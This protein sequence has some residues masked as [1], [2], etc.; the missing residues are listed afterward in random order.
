MKARLNPFASKRLLQIRY[1]FQ[2]ETWERLLQRLAQ[3]NYRAAIVGPEGSGKTTL[4]EDLAIS[5]RNRFVLKWFT[6]S[7]NQE[8]EIPD[9][10]RDHLILLDGFDL[11]PLWKRKWLLW[12]ARSCRGLIVTAHSPTIL[13]TLVE[14]STTPELLYRISQRLVS[15]PEQQL[16]NELFQKHH[17]NIRDVFRELY[18][19]WAA[20]P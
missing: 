6:L 17:G 12:K 8:L 20:L 5:L 19:I 1:E 16:N 11:L 14:C 10:R 4:L 2:Q 15:N 3:F 13:P 7:V 9:I 18:D